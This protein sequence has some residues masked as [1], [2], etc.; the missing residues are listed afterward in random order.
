MDNNW[1]K[2]MEKG[3]GEEKGLGTQYL[4]EDNLEGENITSVGKG[5]WGRAENGFQ[6]EIQASG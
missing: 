1:A 4:E 2:C 3:G 5:R 6:T